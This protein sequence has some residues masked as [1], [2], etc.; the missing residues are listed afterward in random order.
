MAEPDNNN[1]IEDV[2]DSDTANTAD[3]DTADTSD[4]DTVQ[5]A[6]S[7]PQPTKLVKKIEMSRYAADIRKDINISW[8]CLGIIVIMALV[9]LLAR[10][11]TDADTNTNT[12]AQSLNGI[13]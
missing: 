2:E 11:L 13:K 3:A 7:K 5:S 10:M 6:E 8:C 12:N 9:Y 4:I 1:D